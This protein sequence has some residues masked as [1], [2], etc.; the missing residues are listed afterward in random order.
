MK[1]TD[2]R[3]DIIQASLEIIAER[4]FHG[5]PM[6]LIAEKAGVGAGTI[7][8]Y[9]ENKDVL[10]NAL[11]SDVE[12]NIIAALTEGYSEERPVRERFVHLVTMLLKYFVAHPLYFRFMEQYFN[13]PYGVSLRREKILRK[14][15]QRD[16]FTDLFE[17]GTARKVMKDLP[18]PVHAALAFGP[19]IA[20]ARDH[21][22][23]LLELDNALIEQIVKACWDG[24]KRNEHADE[25]NRAKEVLHANR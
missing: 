18:L 19:L 21:I 4:G 8:R 16:L 20:L 6:S 10:I 9:F 22:I 15:D 17:Q 23:G 14:A 3:D 7:Y 25:F 2:K 24:I 11:Y 13:S 12:E 1:K 5:A